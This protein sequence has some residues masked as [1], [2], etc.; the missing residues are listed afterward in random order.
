MRRNFDLFRRED[1][2]LTL[3]FSAQAQVAWPW[4]ECLY[5]D[6]LNPESMVLSAIRAEEEGFDAVL[7]ACFHD[8]PILWEARQAINLP[9]VG[10][11]ESSILMATLSGR[12]FG[13]VASS[14]NPLDD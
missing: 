11:T 13:I 12:R 4:A 3:R 1:T 10:I 2:E 5:L 7:M 9:V 8:A 6:H 14:P